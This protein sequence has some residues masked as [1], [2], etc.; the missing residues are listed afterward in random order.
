MATVTGLTAERMLGIENASVVS[1][2]VTGGDLILVTRGG[3]QINAGT[4]QG[5]QGTPGT[6]GAAG[7]PGPGETVGKISDFPKLPLPAGWLETDGAIYNVA[8]YPALGAYLSNTFGGDGVTTFGVPNYK[9]RTRVHRDAAQLEFD[10][11]GEVG[12][13]KTH[14]L[15]ASQMPVHS[16]PDTLVAPAHTHTIAHVHSAPPGGFVTNPG[17]AG[18]GQSA[19]GSSFQLANV[20]GGST[21]PSSGPASA[22]AL[23]GSVGNAGSGAA[24]NNLQPYAVCVTAIKT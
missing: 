3:T 6:D 17:S 7:P 8:D 2:Q 9:G 1:G 21:T 19:A 10:T 12:G 24:H 18:I 5:P 14:T 22:T 11:V 23:G 4:V 20:T 15:T 16:H 13:A